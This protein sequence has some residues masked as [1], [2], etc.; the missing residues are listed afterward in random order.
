MRRKSSN[1]ALA[2]FQNFLENFC[3]HW[4]NR[5]PIRFVK[6][7]LILQAIDYLHEQE[8][9]RNNETAFRVLQQKKLDK[10]CITVSYLSENYVFMVH[11]HNLI[12]NNEQV[13]EA[14]DH[15]SIR[16]QSNLILCRI[17]DML[18][19]QIELTSTL[20][21][22]LS[23]RTTFPWNKQISTEDNRMMLSHHAVNL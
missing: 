19:N 2:V 10:F 22:I 8:R 14:F 21:I 12:I 18:D 1:F 9:R 6:C 20:Q 16:E 5:S 4:Q 23:K 7:K 3:S 11:E 17:L 13:A 15:L